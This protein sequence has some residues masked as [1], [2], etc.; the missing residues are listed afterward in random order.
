MVCSESG[1]EGGLR[2][3]RWEVSSSVPIKGLSDGFFNVSLMFGLL[4]LGVGDQGATL[5]S[6]SIPLS[7]PLWN[8]G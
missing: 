8:G 5:W 7:K 1:G 2:H 3:W 4:C 6:C